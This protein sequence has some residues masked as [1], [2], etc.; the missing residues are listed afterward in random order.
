VALST[1]R[2]LTSVSGDGASNASD[3]RARK[4]ALWTTSDLASDARSS[5]DGRICR[6]AV[7]F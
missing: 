1:R 6:S 4:Q 2:T 7:S 5:S 3:D